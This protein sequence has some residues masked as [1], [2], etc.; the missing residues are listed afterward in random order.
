M[1]NAYVKNSVWIR[2]SVKAQKVTYSNYTVTPG[3]YTAAIRVLLMLLLLIGHASP[4]FAQ[5]KGQAGEVAKSWDKLDLRRGWIAS[6]GLA[7]V[8]FPEYS[9]SRR[10]RTL[11]IP[12][13]SASW[14]D[15]LSISPLEGVQLNFLPGRALS[16]GTTVTYA[17]G[18]P[19]RGRLSDLARVRGGFASGGFVS[20]QLGSMALGG[21]AIHA[22]SGGLKGYRTR[23]YI[24]WQGIAAP[25]WLFGLKSTL[26]WA[27]HEWAGT[28]YNISP[29]DASRSSLP[30]YS[31]RSGF[32]DVRFN[33]H[34]TYLVTDKTS[35]TAFG[36]VGRLLG[37]AA[38]SPIV[39]EHGRLQ[40]GFAGIMLMRRL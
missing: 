24:N 20:Y 23:I 16:A 31:T 14:E 7:T 32:S 11:P 2:L 35:I 25:R 18:R 38:D 8:V 27:N 15:R 10:F 36:S 4:L 21:D 19:A 12:L 39:R 5:S 1:I 6:I 34:L 9:G 26:T 29:E 40:Q 30:T 13:I 17:R 37:G 28:Y 22:I 33:A 3:F